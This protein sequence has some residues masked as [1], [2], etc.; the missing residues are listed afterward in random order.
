MQ[1]DGYAGA[2]LTQTLRVALCQNYE[3]VSA[4]LGAMT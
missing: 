3:Q 1:W 4:D 2:I